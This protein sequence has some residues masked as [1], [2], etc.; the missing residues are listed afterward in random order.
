MRLRLFSPVVVMSSL[1]DVIQRFPV[2][3][4]L[5]AI[6]GGLS[7]L[8]VSDPSLR[9]STFLWRSII[10][11]VVT[12]PLVV[13]SEYRRQ[14]IYRKV[15][16]HFWTLL[17]VLAGIAYGLLR[18]PHHPDLIHGEGMMRHVFLHIG[19]AWSTLVWLPPLLLR[20]TRE[21]TWTHT[22]HIITSALMSMV[23]AGV[24][25]AGLALAMSAL[26]HL[27]GVHIPSTRYAYLRILISCLYVFPF[28]L[29]HL[30]TQTPLYS[31][32]FQGF[33]TRLSVF[34]KMILWFLVV[35]YTLILIAYSIKVL[36]YGERPQGTV[37]YMVLW[38]YVV[39]VLYTLILLPLSTHSN[40]R[41]LRWVMIGVGIA[42]IGATLLLWWA[43]RE[44]VLAY[45]W[46]VDR[47]LVLLLGLWM[48]LYSISLITT[49]HGIQRL[50]AC[51]VAITV[52]GIY[53]PY[54]VFNIAF[55][56][57]YH[58][59]VDDLRE[60]SFM[61]SE[62]RRLDSAPMSTE[63]ADRMYDRV[64]YL[65]S[66][67][68]LAR[69]DHLID[70]RAVNDLLHENDLRRQDVT[71]ARLMSS[72]IMRTRNIPTSMLGWYDDRGWWWSRW[73]APTPSGVDVDG[74]RYIVFLHVSEHDETT[75]T[76]RLPQMTLTP[77]TLAPL[78]EMDTDE[79]ASDSQRWD[80][81]RWDSQSD[82]AWSTS[83]NASEHEPD[84][85]SFTPHLTV[86]LINKEIIVY[87]DHDEANSLSFADVRYH[88]IADTLLPSKPQPDTHQPPLVVDDEMGRLI[89]LQAWWAGDMIEYL[90]GYLL[91]R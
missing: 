63:V 15:L 72:Y 87:R 51:G 29:H 9:D 69:L 41:R 80:S 14:F 4:I 16:A 35:I 73:Y 34:G 19:I 74:F 26:E 65:L 5:V 11:L 8:S 62:L 6:F 59:L 53:G 50:F 7:F 10:A 49:K 78:L 60:H 83:D 79:D 43:L 82:S 27:F 28:W 47:L 20:R 1:R 33:P 56:D 76:S 13:S 30:P 52:L 25:F 71:S 17:L 36:G 21:V 44:R 23:F 24:L 46:T 86:D 91:L 57:Q 67:H 81:Q 84:N 54:S 18:L 55:T 31:F 45:G 32:G 22:Y 12:F 2:S 70:N 3:I 75:H 90:H 77:S 48:L 37:S 89:I 66:Y 61:F 85:G 42:T 68:G 64:H 58:R 38:F 40:Q 39:V 88:Q